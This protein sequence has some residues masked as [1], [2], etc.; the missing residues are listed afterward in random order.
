MY[1]ENKTDGDEENIVK[2]KELAEEKLIRFRT[3]LNKKSVLYSE[4]VTSARI[5][6]DLNDC[7][8]A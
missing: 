5:L 1:K 2:L 8:G 4:L 7:R 6:V 3:L